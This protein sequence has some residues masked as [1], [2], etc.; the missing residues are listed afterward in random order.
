MQRNDQEEAPALTREYVEASRG[1]DAAK[2]C[3]P[4]S[5]ACFG[6]DRTAPTCGFTLHI[7]ASGSKGNAAIVRHKDTAIL[8]DCGITKRA[9]FERCEAVDF[10]PT[11]LSAIVVTHEHGDHTKGLGVLVRGL[12]KLEVHPALYTTAAIHQASKQ[13]R[14]IEPLVSLQHICAR[15]DFSVEGVR[16]LS[17][18]TSHDSVESMGFRFEAPYVG[19][20]PHSKTDAISQ[21]LPQA[22][23]R[24]LSAATTTD[25]LG[26]VTDTGFL[27][28]EAHAL[29]Q[30]CRILALESNHDSHMLEIGPYPTA[31]KR[32]VS[33]DTGHLSNDQAAA[34]LEALLSNQLEQVAGMHLSETNNLP[35]CCEAALAGI[36]ARNNHPAC[37]WPASQHRPLTLK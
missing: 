19:S 18:P 25:T 36:L 30:D 9:F 33:G 8:I 10:D 7:L 1:R 22:P 32:R 31:L 23:A 4:G 20:P 24:F 12:A 34:A 35:R 17:F 37:V 16:I 27:T 6:A 26:Y 3:T 15:D 28:D 13:L 14:E 11:T 29:L 2:V 5:E 21:A